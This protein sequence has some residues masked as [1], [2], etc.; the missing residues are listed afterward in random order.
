[1]TSH[2]VADQRGFGRVA[3]DALPSAIS[4]WDRDLQCQFA[5]RACD[6]WFGLAPN[7]IVGL[8]LQKVLGEQSF[9]LHHPVAQAALAG[10]LQKIECKVHTHDGVERH[11]IA[12][13]AP[14]FV[15]G[16]VIGLILEM[17]EIMPV[18]DAE[19]AL[20]H[21]AAERRLTGELLRKSEAALRQA[22]RLGQT[23]SWEWEIA[24]DITS[25]SE[26]LYEI[27]GRNPSQLPPT[28]AEHGLLYTPES[29]QRLQA[30]VANAQAT[31]ES[32][33]LELEYIH[34]DGHTGW[35]DAR[36]AA[37]RDESGQV[38]ALHGTVHEITERR[39]SAQLAKTKQQLDAE[40]AKNSQ[41]E[42]ALAQAKRLEVLGLLAGGIAHDFNNVL[43][44]VSGS[45][46]LLKRTAKDD[47]SQT[48]I[49]RGLRGAER[50]TRLVRQ[51][52]GFARTQALEVRTIDLSQE[53]QSCLE[54]LQLSAGPKVKV[55]ITQAP[56]C[57]VLIDPNQLE[58]ALIN[59]TINASDAMPDGG[60][61]VISLDTS[62][63]GSVAIGVRDTGSGMAPDV[64]ERAREPFFTT[65]PAGQGT[66]LGLA[67]VNAFAQQSGGSLALSSRAGEGTCITIVLPRAAGGMAQAVE[68]EDGSIA[69]N[70]H[71]NATVLVVDDDPL[72]RPTV[73]QYLRDLLY[74]VVEAESGQQALEMV[75]WAPPNLVVTDF[76]MQSM[77][78]AT[79]ATRLRLMQPA[80]PIL[81]IT[82]HAD[83]ERLAG[84]EVL[85][86]PFTQAR[87]ADRVLR[88]LGRTSPGQ[89]RLA[90]RIKHPALQAL[91]QTWHQ[92]RSGQA[93][94]SVRSL[95]LD[96]CAAPE[97]VFVG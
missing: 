40:I 25:W 4:Y 16:N 24:T 8:S 73:V 79:L 18:H 46:H 78:G 94:P 91:Y 69:W 19:V 61:I 72:V 60:D 97:N 35:L 74:T 31:G 53:L 39:R 80:L 37:E 21:E 49:D 93:L 28:Y 83:R 23:G 32:Y 20:R 81:V 45:L 42:K 85:D 64:L 6:T 90:G 17:V 13:Y 3:L 63:A 44:A 82:G 59:L 58:V 47:R 54:L 95:A 36:G 56:P 92:Q 43:A 11:C 9:L 67:M 12:H 86:K 68:R 10:K 7:D 29:W 57:M 2:Q 96:V 55:S 71:G 66:G 30:A 5:N 1:M 76:A 89:S 88:L 27:F 41:L 77:D 26:Q 65:K 22:Q 70:R 51:L 15:D 84:E 75:R 33:A 38:V 62:V 52:M 50:A 14:A 34:T 87:L 48:L